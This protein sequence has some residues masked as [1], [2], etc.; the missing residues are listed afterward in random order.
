MADKAMILHREVIE[1]A[2]N[3]FMDELG[4]HKDIVMQYTGV[5]D[6]SGKEIYEGDIIKVVSVV[7]DVK[8]E[9]G[10]N[11]GLAGFFP[12]ISFQTKQN[13]EVIGNI[14]ENEDLL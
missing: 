8:Y 13:F 5:K 11:D 1:R 7:G 10:W 6:K 9:V 14:Y 2:H 12:L 3:Q 4:G